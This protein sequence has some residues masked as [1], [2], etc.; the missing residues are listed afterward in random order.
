VSNSVAPWKQDLK[1]EASA[2]VLFLTGYNLPAVIA[3]TGYL[4]TI[5]LKQWKWSCND[6]K[7]TKAINCRRQNS[8]QW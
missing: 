5:F 2:V 3:G 4:Q 6:H 7:R 1:L 8:A